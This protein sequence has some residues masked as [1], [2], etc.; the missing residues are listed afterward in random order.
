MSKKTSLISFLLG[1][2]ILFIYFLFNDYY[3]F[4]ERSVAWCDMEQQYIP[5]L[6]EQI[7]RASCRERV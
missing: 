2:A 4:G 6:L 1:T 5:L 3:P 7:G